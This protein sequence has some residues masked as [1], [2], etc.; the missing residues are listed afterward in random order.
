MTSPS[1]RQRPLIW[2]LAFLSTAGYGALY[3]AQPL[4][5]VATEH[6]TGWSRAQTGLAFTLALLTNAALAPVVGRAVD[7]FGGRALISGGAALG[8]AALA[9]LS[10]HPTYLGF[11]A[12]WVLAG[13]AM[14][15]TFYEPVF[16]VVA[17]QFQPADRRRATLTIT[18][19][20]GL[21]STIFVPLTSA[22]LQAGGLT[23]ALGTL[24]GLLLI[25][26]G[27][28]W[29][30]LPR[31]G[32]DAGTRTGIRPGFQPDP[33][34][35]RLV[36][37]FTLARIVSVGTGLQLAPL[38][39][40]RGEASAVAAALAG[41][42]GLAALPG[43][44]LFAPLLNGLGIRRL[45]ALLFVTLGLGLLLLAT[46]SSTWAAAVAITLFGL[47]NG[48]LT[49]ARTELLLARYDAN[50]FGT[51]NGWLAWPVNLAQALTPFAVGL[52][53]SWGGS[54]SPSLWGLTGLAALSAWVVR[55]ETL[56]PA[57]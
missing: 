26:A 54:Y 41:L 9:G 24:A 5:A 11:V 48:A 43:R 22:G 39:L 17:Q 42:M 15:L 30:V 10:L 47:A 18:L 23:V 3:Y 38:L 44:V 25:T 37:S 1:P 53:F 50:R 31:A 33:A 35:R 49:L 29:I 36:L 51:V 52:L 56:D 6:V 20:A 28:G 27:L 2:T 45:T 12:C 57:A 14:T 21:A 19:V 55:A 40:A 32:H 4:L 7:R 16:V 13:V 46:L 8:A 34:F